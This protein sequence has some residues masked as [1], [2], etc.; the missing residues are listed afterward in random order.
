M[1]A[2]KKFWGSNRIR[3]YDLHDTSAM[4]CQL[5]YEALLEAGQE[6][7]EFIPQCIHVIYTIYTSFQGAV[8]KL[9]YSLLSPFSRTVRN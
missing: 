8:C 6:Q 1:K 2:Q 4:L 9:I 3:T 5:S 7:V